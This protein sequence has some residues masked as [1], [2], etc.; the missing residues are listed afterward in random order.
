MMPVALEFHNFAS[1]MLLLSI[2]K[3]ERS[4][5]GFTS[6]NIKSIL[7]QFGQTFH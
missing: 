5:V 2:A 4:D 3:Y 7:M 1:D 6:K